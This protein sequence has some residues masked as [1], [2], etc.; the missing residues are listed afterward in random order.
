MRLETLEAPLICREFFQRNFR[1]VIAIH[2]AG[3]KAFHGADGA[4]KGFAIGEI[5]GYYGSEVALKE[6]PPITGRQGFPSRTSKPAPVQSLWTY[7]LDAA[8]L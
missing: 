8:W 5:D 4:G 1:A 2:F 3:G 7:T 6:S